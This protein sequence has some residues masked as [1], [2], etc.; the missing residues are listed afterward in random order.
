VAIAW[1]RIGIVYRHT[2]QFEQAERAYRQSL[3]VRV[4]Q[5]DRSGEASSLGELGMLYDAM[6]RL[7]EAVTFH[8]QAA[9]IY[10]ALAD[11]VHEGAVRNNLAST[12]MTLQR[13]DDARQAL[14]RAIECN[15]PF[16]HAAIPW[17]TWARLHNL[18]QAIGNGP[19]A[20]EAWQQAVQCY[21]AYRRAGGESQEPGA[22][23]CARIARGINRGDNNGVTPLLSPG[24]AAARTPHLAKNN[25]PQLT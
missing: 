17:T 13:Y 18:E 1:H 10:V 9:D 21:L 11:L 14:Q 7:E 25:Q 8:R 16:G 2:R 6:G 20:A 15:K 19:A 3:A 24:P 5:Q 23:L 12:L 22:Q 4:R